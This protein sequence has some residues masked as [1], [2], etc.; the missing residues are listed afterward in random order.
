MEPIRPFSGVRILDLSHELGSYATRLFAD[1]GADVIR[2]EPS[3][4]L[5]DRATAR[6]DEG[7]AAPDY[8]FIFMNASKRSIVLDLEKSDDWDRFA[9]LAEGSQII[10]VERGGPLYDNLGRLREV[11]PKA[12]ITAVSPFGMSGP[13]AD[14]P[15]SDL[16]LQAA[17]GIA[18]LSGRPD[19]APLRLPVD[20]SITITSVYAAAATAIA[21]LHSEATG[22]GHLIDVSAQECIA[23]SLQNAIQVWDLEHRISRRGGEGTRDAS[24][25]IFPCKD[26]YVFIASP[27]TLG[28]SWKSLVAWMT[29]IGHPAVKEF[30]QERWLDRRWR[31]S[32]EARVLFR[33]SFETFSRD[34]TK[35]ELAEAAIKRKIVMAPVSRVSDLVEDEQLAYRGFFQAVEDPRFEKP[36]DFPGAPYRLSEDVWAI[37]PAPE[38]GQDNDL[39]EKLSQ[40]GSDNKQ[41]VDGGRA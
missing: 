12:V 34:F 30:G 35:Q 3:G 31:L 14:A 21:F 26:G 32:N 29:E 36:V 39:V 8:A 23:H 19:D 16:T 33:E 6:G 40:P 13:W 15:A 38:L 1:L 18:W 17:G 28:V 10:V 5:P 2:V 22:T 11:A 25:D 41:H 20:Q 24:E 4:G 37:R 7:N 9:T 27:P